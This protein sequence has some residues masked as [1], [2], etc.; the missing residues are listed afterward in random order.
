MK[1]DPRDT[2]LED[3][4][5]EVAGDKKAKGIEEVLRRSVLGC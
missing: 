1:S 2:V 3:D 4:R 5:E